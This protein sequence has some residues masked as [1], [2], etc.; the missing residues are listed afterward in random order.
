MNYH[1]DIAVCLVHY[2]ASIEVKV[3]LAVKAARL[4][5]FLPEPVKYINAAKESLYCLVH[6]VMSSHVRSVP[7]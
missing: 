1:L 4:T 7:I 6:Y 3:L 5:A 2:A